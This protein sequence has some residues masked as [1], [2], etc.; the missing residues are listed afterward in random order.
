MTYG[1]AI[2]R[3]AKI[4]DVDLLNIESISINPYLEA[5]TIGIYAVGKQM[6]RVPIT[7][8][9]GFLCPN[10]GTMA[11]MANKF[12][13]CTQCGQRLDWKGDEYED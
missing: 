5:L 13:Y 11:N 2:S 6:P 7:D 10:C 8:E 1:E 4:R 9:V 3:L 12:K